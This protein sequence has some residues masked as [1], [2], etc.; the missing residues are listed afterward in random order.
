MNFWELVYGN[1]G[2]QVI[3]TPCQGRQPKHIMKR[4]NMSEPIT[5]LLFQP[6]TTGGQ[7]G[8]TPESSG[9]SPPPSLPPSQSN[10]NLSA[11]SLTCV[12]LTNC[13]SD[14]STLK[15]I[16][17]APPLKVNPHPERLQLEPREVSS[18]LPFSDWV[19]QVDLLEDLLIGWNKTLFFSPR[20][21]DTHTE[22]IPVMRQTGVCKARGE[23]GGC[24]SL[25]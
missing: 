8:N 10:E 18:P 2:P 13:Y 15:W 22:Q 14:W 16:S 23:D 17:V 25:W 24:S 5:V 20:S 21:H 12:L 9:T 3:A 19:F 7:S 11:H 4:W 1:S 6:S